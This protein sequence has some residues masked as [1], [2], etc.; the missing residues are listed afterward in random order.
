M[1]TRHSLRRL[2]SRTENNRTHTPPQPSHHSDSV[3][4][5]AES[6]DWCGE[7]VI[8]E[9]GPAALKSAWS[10]SAHDKPEEGRRM[11]YRG[12]GRGVGMLGVGRWGGGGEVRPWR[13]WTWW[14]G[15]VRS[16]V[17]I[18]SRHFCHLRGS[19]PALQCP[20][21]KAN[22]QQGGRRRDQYFMK[23]ARP[24][25]LHWRRW[26]HRRGIKRQN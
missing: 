6:K 21:I 14:A 11:I 12:L 8:R 24:D 18:P 4:H 23:A 16:F 25:G 1:R 9:S 22:A 17:S 10:V 13:L 2:Q 20:S 3:S 26:R 15:S 5:Y 19:I 7:V